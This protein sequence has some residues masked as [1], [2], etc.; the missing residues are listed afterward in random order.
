MT[1][2]QF[3]GEDVILPKNLQI[4]LATDHF[5]LKDRFHLSLAWSTWGP[6]KVSAPRLSHKRAP[7]ETPRTIENEIEKSACIKNIKKSFSVSDNCV[8]SSRKMIS[9]DNGI[10]DLKNMF[11]PKFFK[12]NMFSHIAGRKRAGRIKAMPYESSPGGNLVDGLPP[13]P[14]LRFVLQI[15]LSQTVLG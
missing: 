9:S 11:V 12:S 10:E 7:S 8:L 13:V 3:F 1:F 14:S 5:L 4:R 6:G 2:W 15:V